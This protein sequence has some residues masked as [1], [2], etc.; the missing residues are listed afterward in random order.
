MYDNISLTGKVVPVDNFY[1]GDLA[2]GDKALSFAEKGLIM[3]GYGY[4]IQN[5]AIVD[6]SNSEAYLKQVQSKQIEENFAVNE[7]KY[8]L[9]L[10]TPIQ[11]TNGK[12][13]KPSYVDEYAKLLVTDIFPIRIWDATGLDSDEMTKEELKL[14]VSFLKQTSE[15]AF[16]SYKVKKAELLIEKQ[17]I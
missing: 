11:Y 16:Q 6:I 12:T 7:C 17:N 2:E 8:N 10:T 9:V 4:E 15:P 1:N 3:R 14:L 13:Y 5:H